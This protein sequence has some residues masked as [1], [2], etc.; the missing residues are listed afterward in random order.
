MPGHAPVLELSQ[1][2]PLPA[3]GEPA[4]GE[5]DLV[6]MRGDLALVNV[7][8]RRRA[9]WFADLCSGLVPLA[10]GAI[11]FLG[12]EWGH[13]PDHYAAAL[14][15]RIGRIFAD[16]GWVEFLDMAT[17]ILLPQLH[18]TREDETELRER[19][20]ELAYAFGLP[21]LPLDRASELS[22]LDLARCSCVRA[23]LGKPALLLLESPVQGLFAELKAPLLEAIAS[24]RGEG[25]AVVWLTR[26][27]LVWSDR[28]FPAACRLNL[29]ERGLAPARPTA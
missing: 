20:T 22:A 21:G 14:R 19:A 29:H 10:G 15:G 18:H 17:N 8:E 3:P 16:G 2:R 23:F 24:A 7:R 4:P 5:I 9:A 27:D 26:S 25:A 11:R 1:I 6:L 12:R 28:S 13:V